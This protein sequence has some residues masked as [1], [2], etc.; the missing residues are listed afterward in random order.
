MITPNPVASK[1]V[2]DASANLIFSS[3]MGINVTQKTYA[4]IKRTIITANAL[5]NTARSLDCRVL[6]R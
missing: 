6:L 1:K 5:R 3:A 2:R 4:K